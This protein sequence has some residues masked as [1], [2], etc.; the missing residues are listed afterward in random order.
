MRC[1]A[2]YRGPHWPNEDWALACTGRD[3]LK[4]VK[5]SSHSQICTTVTYITLVAVCRVHLREPNPEAFLMLQRGLIK[6]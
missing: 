5:N 2:S 4:Y 6:A 3:L 1:G